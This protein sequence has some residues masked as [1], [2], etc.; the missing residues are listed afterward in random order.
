MGE[1]GGEGAGREGGCRGR[2]RGGAAGTMY[3]HSRTT[4]GENASCADK[5]GEGRCG[6]EGRGKVC[7]HSQT[8]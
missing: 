5:V 1:R 3:G 7:G 4:L 6:R 8:V 2:K